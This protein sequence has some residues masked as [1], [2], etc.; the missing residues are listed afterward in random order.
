MHGGHFVY[1]LFISRKIL[2]VTCHGLRVKLLVK[3]EG[4][5][6]ENEGVEGVGKRS[7]RHGR[8]RQISPIQWDRKSASCD[9]RSGSEG[10]MSRKSGQS[11]GSAGSHKRARIASSVSRKGKLVQV[12]PA[13]LRELVLL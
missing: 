11:G 12:S 7:R 10:S 4:E 9:S 1:S 8:K 13:N 2:R 6:D 5:K 3:F